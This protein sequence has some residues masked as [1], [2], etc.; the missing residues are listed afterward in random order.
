MRT[1]ED[2]RAYFQQLSRDVEQG[3]LDAFMPIFEAC[4]EHE[5]KHPE[6]VDRER[7]AIRA[8]KEFA[9]YMKGKRPLKHPLIEYRRRFLR[10]AHALTHPSTLH[11]S[12]YTTCR[13]LENGKGDLLEELDDLLFWNGV[14][15]IKPDE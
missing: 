8:T 1:K 5:R 2:S 14:K 7:I 12:I 4:A 15:E 6:V 10:V 13:A 11:F 9:L 3:G